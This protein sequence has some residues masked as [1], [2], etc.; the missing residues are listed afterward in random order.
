M[1]RFLSLVLAL[2]L[3]F[4]C[5]PARAS[6]AAAPA[7]ED[8]YYDY[9]FGDLLSR[10]NHPEANGRYFN[11]RY[12]AGYAFDLSGDDHPVWF[13]LH[14]VDGNGVPELIA[15]DGSEG[16]DGQ[17]HL[18]TVDSEGMKYLG[19]AWYF[20]DDGRIYAYRDSFPGLFVSRVLEEGAPVSTM[21]VTEMSGTLHTEPVYRLENAGEEPWRTPDALLRA[22]DE[23]GEKL[24]FE[25]A[26]F[27]DLIFRDKASFL[28]ALKRTGIYANAGDRPKKEESVAWLSAYR[29]F[30][31][32]SQYKRMMTPMPADEFSDGSEDIYSYRFYAH[33][34]NGDS[35]PELIVRANS[36]REQLDIYTFSDGKVVHAATMGGDNFI[37]DVFCFEDPLLPSGVYISLGGP[38]RD[39]ERC[40]YENGAFRSEKIGSTILG[41]GEDGDYTETV[42]FSRTVA[43]TDFLAEAITLTG[44]GYKRPAVLLTWFEEDVLETDAQWVD[45]YLSALKVNGQGTEAYEKKA[46]LLRLVDGAPAPGTLN[47]WNFNAGVTDLAWLNTVLQALHLDLSALKTPL[48]H[49][50]YLF[51]QAFK[52]CAEGNRISTVNVPKMPEEVKLLNKTADLK[53]DELLDALDAMIDPE[54]LKLFD[55]PTEMRDVFGDYIEGKIDDVR[56]WDRY[57]FVLNPDQYEL[58]GDIDSK[59]KAIRRI[60]EVSKFLKGL[61]DAV[62]IAGGAVD[63][64]N[65]IM[66]M[67]AM[68]PEIGEVICDLYM[69]SEDDVDGDGAYYTAGRRLQRI[70]RTD[71]NPREQVLLITTGEIEDVGIDMLLDEI[72]LAKPP[73]FAAAYAVTDVATGAASYAKAMNKLQWACELLEFAET[74]MNRALAAYLKND[75]DEN[76]TKLLYLY[77]FYLD[78][79]ASVEEAYAGVCKWQQETPIARTPDFVIAQK[80]ESEEKGKALRSLAGNI[81]TAGYEF[82]NYPYEFEVQDSVEYCISLQQELK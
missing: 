72:K 79:C 55:M 53:R 58:I 62:K 70:V 34:I 38:G 47:G 7:W 54:D 12:G 49:R 32:E 13:I 16:G 41:P 39:F 1:K 29:R 66:L 45:F 20:G 24:Y 17:V 42:G 19:S 78:V 46:A 3:A 23:H 61:G 52:S 48:Q 73:F 2:T 40:W 22:L 26:V 59:L 30:I 31:S 36:F 8:A 37:D 4:A 25:P 64:Y 68:N 81:R 6:A 28:R 44:Y 56:L 60:G 65:Q 21:Y 74:G 82:R 35:V 57:G 51:E 18:Y 14:D 5:A 10:E 75:T 11:D 43:C 77:T 67:E 50:K 80:G 76:F 63:I 33:D 27:S 71:G 69:Y 15:C 9:F